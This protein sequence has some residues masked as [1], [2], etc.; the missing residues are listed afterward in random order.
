MSAGRKMDAEEQQV[1][2]VINRTA[3]IEN[4]LNQV[5]EN[6]C[7]PHEDRFEFFWDVVLDSSIMPVAS[8][9]KV[10]MA[11]AQDAKFK[12]DQDAL[13]KVMALRNAFAH[14]QTGSHP[15]IVAGKKRDEESVHFELQV[16]S[17]SG[18][19]TRKK[20]Q[21]AYVEFIESFRAAEISLTDLLAHI[22]GHGKS[23]A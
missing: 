11:V 23:P 22:R 3:Y 4:L 18:R 12:L 6:Y 20:R 1:I 17:N 16:I 19:I 13:H 9:V 14:H 21:D 2:E 8:K 15:V 10:A 5:I 7:N